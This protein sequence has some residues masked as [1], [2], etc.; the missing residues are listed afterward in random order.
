MAIDRQ[1]IYASSISR[2]EV[3]RRQARRRGELLG[4]RL[5]LVAACG[6][7]FSVLVIVVQQVL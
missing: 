6:A 5:A 2:R 7:G 4:P 1:V 3:R